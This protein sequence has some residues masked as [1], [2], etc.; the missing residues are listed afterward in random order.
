[1]LK[2]IGIGVAVLVVG[3]VVLVATRPSTFTVERSAS[4]NAP[5]DVV[6]A[7]VADFHG[8]AAWSPWEKLDPALKRT[9]EGAP[10]GQGAI[11]RW[12]GNDKVG[13]GR[14]TIVGAKPGEQVE[15][16]LEFIKPFEATSQTLFTFKPTGD[17]TQVTWTMNGNNNFMAKLVTLF[18]NFDASVGGDFERGLA[19][20][21]TVAEDEAK[22]RAAAAAAPKPAEAGAP[23]PAP[24]Q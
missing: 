10:S 19:A 15:I 2:K 23:P 11:Y 14:M 6:Y 5:A 9:Y 12:V 20:L 4:I 3:L 24:A 16:K 13:E 7:Q 22:K 1:M 8:W 21:K 17:A 18:V